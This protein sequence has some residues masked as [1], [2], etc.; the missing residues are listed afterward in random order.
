MRLSGCIK[1]LFSQKSEGSCKSRE[2][3][4]FGVGSMVYSE[5]SQ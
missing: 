3:K 2:A 1:F 5:E 4:Q